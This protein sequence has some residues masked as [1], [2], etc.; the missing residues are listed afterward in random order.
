M[1]DERLVLAEEQTPAVW[2]PSGEVDSALRF[3]VDAQLKI[4]PEPEPVS[5]DT[6]LEADTSHFHVVS[7]T[8]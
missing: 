5:F 4:E 3:R 1:R 8:R 6:V 7:E 2:S